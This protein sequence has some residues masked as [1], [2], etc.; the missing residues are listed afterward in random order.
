MDQSKWLIAPIKT[1]KKK[2]PLK[3]PLKKEVSSN[4]GNPFIKNYKLKN[5]TKR[6]PIIQTKLRR[7]SERE[8]REQ[9]LMM[10][11]HVAINWNL[12]ILMAIN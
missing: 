4:L 2:N 10:G 9:I 12:L 1:I 6:D 11:M 5:W 3:S 8:K 7:E